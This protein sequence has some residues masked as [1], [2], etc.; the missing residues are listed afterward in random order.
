MKRTLSLIAVSLVAAASLAAC[1][2]MAPVLTQAQMDADLSNAVTLIAN[3]CKIVQPTVAGVAPLTG[4]AAV[5][6]GAA[7][8]GVFCAANEAAAA[9][10]ASAPTAA[11]TP[12]ASQ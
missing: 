7:A 2:G 6:V 12:A 9:G 1:N 8:N 11:S 4:N 5:A 3:G 10:A